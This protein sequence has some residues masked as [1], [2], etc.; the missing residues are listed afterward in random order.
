[1]QHFL[2]QMLSRCIGYL[3]ISPHGFMLDVAM[4]MVTKELEDK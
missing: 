2:S 4:V 3:Q 1:M